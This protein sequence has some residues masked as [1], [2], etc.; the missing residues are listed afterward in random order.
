MLQAN[1]S[2]VLLQRLIESEMRQTN[3]LMKLYAFNLSAPLHSALSF[4]TLSFLLRLE[5]A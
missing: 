2:I 3:K 4:E 1:K 5:G